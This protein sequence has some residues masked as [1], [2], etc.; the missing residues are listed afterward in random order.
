M[1]D[2]ITEAD[3]NRYLSEVP[4][5]VKLPS[6]KQIFKRGLWGFGLEIFRRNSHRF[7]H[8]EYHITIKVPTKPRKFW[9]VNYDG[10]TTGKRG[11]LIVIGKVPMLQGGWHAR[12]GP[13]HYDVNEKFPP[14]RIGYVNPRNLANY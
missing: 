3:V 6:E 12:G 7:A 2:K 1:R 13:I 14:M 5:Y 10:I 11:W 4:K 8:P 9:S